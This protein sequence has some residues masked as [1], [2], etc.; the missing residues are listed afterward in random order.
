VT[1]IAI[2]PSRSPKRIDARQSTEARPVWLGP[3]R[4]RW[5]AWI[6]GSAR[7]SAFHFPPADAPHDD[8]TAKVE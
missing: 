6:V 7:F 1:G 5:D 8:D 4:G 2:A 3:K